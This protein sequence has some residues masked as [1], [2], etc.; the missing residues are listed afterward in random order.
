ME[1]TSFLTLEDAESKAYI[2][3]LCVRLELVQG[4]LDKVLK[5]EGAKERRGDFQEYGSTGEKSSAGP[6]G[7][8][9]GEI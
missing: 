6:L 3:N 5:E 7:E 4:L 8:A 2:C 1:D 9:D